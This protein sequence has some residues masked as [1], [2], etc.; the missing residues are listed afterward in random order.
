M[1]PT[2]HDLDD[3]DGYERSHGRR[4]APNLH[5]RTLIYV[6]SGADDEWMDTPGRRRGVVGIVGR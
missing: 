6:A 5:F 2:L 4:G 3:A 1:T